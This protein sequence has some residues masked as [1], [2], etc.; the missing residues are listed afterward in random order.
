V[1]I[2]EVIEKKLVVAILRCLLF[3]RSQFQT[4]GNGMEKVLLT[5]YSQF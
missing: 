2:F 3:T 1:E 5:S 4:S